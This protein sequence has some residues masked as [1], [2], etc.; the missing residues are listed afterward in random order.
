MRSVNAFVLMVLLCASMVAVASDGAMPPNVDKIAA[1]LVQRGVIP[2]NA[3]PADKEAAVQNYLKAKLGNNGLDKGF[4]PEAHRRLVANENALNAAQ[5]SIRGKK[6]GNTLAVEPSQ[7]QFMP[8]QGTG[9]LLLILVEFSNTP[10]TWTTGAGTTRTEAGPMHNQIPVPDNSF[11]LYVPDFNTQHYEDMLFTPG[12]WYFPSDAPRYAGE[13][14]GSMHDFYLQQ[15]FGQYTVTGK[16]YGWFT[17]NKPEAYYGDDNTGNDN[18]SPGN[19]RTL[20]ADA[21]TV[22][23]AQNAINWEEY[24]TD[25]NC[26]IDH[27]LFI[28]AGVDQSGGGGAQG[29]DAIWAHSSSTNIKVASPAYCGAGGLRIRN[30]TIMPEDGGVGVFAHE[31]GHDLGLPDEYDTIYSG[32]GDSI[33]YWSLM[34][35][36]SWIGKPAQTQPSDMSIW[37]RYSL[38]W[39]GP[40]L[41]VTSVGALLNQ[42]VNVRLEQSERWGGQGS[43]N[44]VRINL[45]N[46]IL[47]M[48][49]PFSGSYEWWGG[50]GD[51]IDTTLTRTIDLTGKTTAT[52]TF[53]T[54]YDIEPYWDFAFV[55]VS[56]DGGATFTSLAVDGT[57]TQMETGAY[58]TIAPN[59]PG[60]TGKSGGWVPKTVDLSAYAGQTIQFRFRY[61]T[62]WGTNMAGFFVDDLKVVAD[63]AVVFTDTE[64][65]DG[66]WTADGFARSQ[67]VQS[68]FHYYLAEWRNTAP[69]ET[70]YGGISL[71]N[72]D[73]GLTN[74]YQYDSYG[75]NPNEPYYYPFASPGVLL[76]YRDS[77]YDDNWTGVH[78]G[79]GY[80]LV[81][82][83]REAPMLRPSAPGIG[84][85]P[86]SS[87]VQSYDAVF[88][89]LPAPTI[90]I[91]YW[92]VTKNEI[93]KNAV[94]NFDDSHSYWTSKVPD[95]SVITPRYGFV[96][97]VLG[98]ADDGSAALV[99]F[100]TK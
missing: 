41:G 55:Q 72:F 13:H 99:G 43:Y 100:G 64:A 19:P 16:A 11:D 32:R 12:G 81:V 59:L 74:A 44:G 27:P 60:F 52:L 20:L 22:I 42:P 75:A 6:L 92:G 34:S 49:K 66:G 56:T 25:H 88:S 68:K 70:P 97:R 45:P 71:V 83:S 65:S 84:S 39:M 28:H 87:R 17:V 61:I 47:V 94:P 73:N 30:Y 82:D 2:A 86:W 15:S 50:R 26:V 96:F 53:Y 77:S 4:N 37:G 9:K 69:M 38:G 78:P 36:G 18:M 33:G 62:D 79:G 76:W 40:N 5:G 10:Y 51:E 14:R 31:F 80:L 48:N 67:G 1:A 29:D 89:L 85:I 35:T 23:N 3:S 63:G 46:K 24:D 7:P 8:L 21:V 90:T 95:A 93:G 57:T 54:W 98:Q 91:G 58:P